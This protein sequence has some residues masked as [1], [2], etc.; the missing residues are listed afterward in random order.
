MSRLWERQK[1]VCSLCLVAISVLA[2]GVATLS[3]RPQP[4]HAQSPPQTSTCA[5]WQS[6]SD[7]IVP[8]P[9]V[10]DRT[11]AVVPPDFK[12]T[13]LQGNL[14]LYS[15]ITFLAVDWPASEGTCAP[16]TSLSIVTSPTNPVWMTYLQDSDVFVPAGQKPAS[17]C[18]VASNVAAAKASASLTKKQLAAQ[19]S[20]RLAHL[21]PNVRALAMKHPEVRLFL[22]HNAKAI[23]RTALK[24]VAR[25]AQNPSLPEILQAT[26]D[27]LV[28]QNGRWAR[29]TVAMNQD[30]YNYVMSKTLWTKAGQKSAGTVSF[31]LTPTGSMEF[32]SAW[33]VLGAGDNPSHFV[34][35]SAIVY[36]D[37][38]GEPSPGP[39]PV[40]VGLVGLHITHKTNLQHNWI[41]STFEQVEN[42]TTSFYNARCPASQCP[43]NKTTVANPTTALELN[44]QGKPN[45]APAQV[46][47]ITPTSAQKLNST[48]QAMLAGSPWAYYQLIS[49]QW[50]GE[51]GTG[52]KPAQL[53]NS[54][55]E[56]FLPAGTN[57]SCMTCHSYATLAGAAST[58]ADFSY[59]LMLS[60][61]Q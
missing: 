6:S 54:V 50:V 36:N 32:K 10:I 42:D 14:D 1:L 30:E 7:P 40:S 5:Q 11:C 34:T 17:W 19:R 35:A 13:P 24:G 18:F 20:F 22:H 49:T 39:N 56:T 16:D 57:Y 45:F 46:V 47:P 29:F 25:N 31:P 23:D 33:K 38:N 48:F 21:P 59:L 44:A 37:V 52:P 28:D 41:W 12:G 43:P 8:V 51:E 60:V 27:I 4:A 58:S 15:W 55:Q 26:G 3:L 9:T 2:V 61:K 53:G